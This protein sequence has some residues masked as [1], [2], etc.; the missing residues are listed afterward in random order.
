MYFNRLSCVR[1]SSLVRALHCAGDSSHTSRP[2][3]DGP[4][5]PSRNSPSAAPVSPHDARDRMMPSAERQGAT[6]LASGVGRV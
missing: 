6:L 5:R 2:S 4:A 1:C 3:H